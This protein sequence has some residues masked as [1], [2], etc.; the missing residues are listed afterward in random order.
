M[1]LFLCSES[2]TDVARLLSNGSESLHTVLFLACS[3]MTKLSLP[4]QFA[5]VGS[6][7]VVADRTV[8]LLL[9]LSAM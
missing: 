2:R 7:V 5:I 3:D 9:V 8:A 6:V 4:M 1:S